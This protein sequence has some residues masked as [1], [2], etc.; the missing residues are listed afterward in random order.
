M[1]MG[2][3]DLDNRKE[4]CKAGLRPQAVVLSIDPGRGVIRAGHQRF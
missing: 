3:V 4:R 1:N 2:Q